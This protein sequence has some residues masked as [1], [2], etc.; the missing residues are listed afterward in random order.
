[1]KSLPFPCIHYPQAY[2]QAAQIFRATQSKLAYCLIACLAISFATSQEAAAQDSNQ[3]S[4]EYA[5]DV[6][7]EGAV[8]NRNGQ[9]VAEYLKF[10][11]AK[12]VFAALFAP[13]GQRLTRK[14]PISDALPTEKLDHVHHR[15]FWFTHGEV[16]DVDFWAEAKNHGNI[17]ETSFEA[18]SDGKSVTMTTTNQWQDAT[19][20][21]LLS[22]QRDYKF[23]DSLGMRAIDCTI[24]LIASDGPVVFGDTKEGSFGVRVAG[25]MKV[26]SKKGGKIVSSAGLE[27]GATWG[28]Q[29]EWVDYYGPVDGETVGIAILNHPSSYGFPTRWHVR[30]YGLFAANP[31]GVH[32]F[33]GGDRTDGVR[34]EDGEELTLKY[35][36][37]LHDGT[38]EEAEISKAWK[39]Y[40][41]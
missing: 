39:E 9:P 10:S 29:A 6:N 24:R 30:T 4:A 28:K 21:P 34:L 11:G 38:T 37:L 20:K 3:E 18:D 33:A 13:S 41:Q 17:V 16:N 32:H 5:I 23:H 8:I 1:M 26:D 35:R 15:S 2:P 7:D 12:P 14:Y 31:F 36:V 27:D 22:D 19:G 40:A 25:T